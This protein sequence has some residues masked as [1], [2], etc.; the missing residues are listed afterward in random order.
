MSFAD[1]ELEYYRTSWLPSYCCR[2]QRTILSAFCFILCGYLCPLIALKCLLSTAGAQI[3]KPQN[4]CV[5]KNTYVQS[6]ESSSDMQAVKRRHT[7]EQDDH[8]NREHPTLML[9]QVCADQ[10]WVAQLPSLLESG[11]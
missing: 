11:A 8:V 1:L 3:L 7:I 2:F 6:F 5:R 10:R 4:K 9:G